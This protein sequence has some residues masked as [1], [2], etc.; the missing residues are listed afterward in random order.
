MILAE[1]I[2][3][4]FYQYQI[5]H[6]TYDVQINQSKRCDKIVKTEKHVVASADPALSLIGLAKSLWGKLL[7]AGGQ[8]LV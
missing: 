2:Y 1:Q 5:L 4:I 3:L 7:K 8:F 6:R